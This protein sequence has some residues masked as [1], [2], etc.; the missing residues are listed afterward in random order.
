MNIICY[1]FVCQMQGIDNRDLESAWAISKNWFWQKVLVS[2]IVNSKYDHNIQM[3][4][5][6]SKYDQNFSTSGSINPCVRSFSFFNQRI[7]NFQIFK[8]GNKCYF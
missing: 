1:I 2:L 3:T 7:R 6:M 5:Q 8:T 4:M